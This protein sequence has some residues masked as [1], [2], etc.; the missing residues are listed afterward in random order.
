MKKLIL[1]CVAVL[2]MAAAP[3]PKGH[4]NDFANIIPD[5][6]EAVLEQSLRDYEAKTTIEMAVVTTPSLEGQTI[7]EYSIALATEWGIG[8]KGADNGVLV[9]IAPNDREYRV[10]V[11]R[12]LEGDLT[13]AD[14]DFMARE[15]L[16]PA[17]RADPPD[18]AGGIETL[19]QSI[20]EHLGPM[21]PDQRA[22][23]QRKRKAAEER[24]TELNQ[25]RAV[26]FFGTVF[27]VVFSVAVVAFLGILVLTI[28]KW[29]RAR[30]REAERRRNLR[31]ALSAVQSELQ[32]L[33]D[34]RSAIGLPNL[35]LWMQDD[36]ELH[37][38]AFGSALER[39]F[40]LVA[41]IESQSKRNLGYA[42]L[43]KGELDR[44]LTSV[45]ASL[46]MLQTIP[47]QVT[48]FRTQTEQVVA[49][50]VAEIDELTSRSATLI[51][52]GYRIND[53]VPALDLGRLA[54]ERESIV[55]LLAT[56]GEGLTDASEVVNDKAT[57]L[58][59]KVRSLR[60]ALE[61]SIETQSSSARR[62][63]ALQKRVQSFPAL[64]AEHRARLGRLRST[65]PRARW[66]SF[67]EGLPV[68]ERTMTGVEP[69]LH[70]ATHANSMEAQLF[71]DAAATLAT[72]ETALG[73]IDAS[74]KGATVLEATVATAE[75]E[76]PSR[77][78]SVER[79]I[80]AAQRLMSDSDVGSGAKSRLSEAKRFL[81]SIQVP[82]PLVDWIGVVNLL[83]QASAKAEQAAQLAR[84]DI[85]SA[86]REQRRRQDEEDR[87][88]RLSQAAAAATYTSSGFGQSS[89][90]GGDS[91]GGFGGGSFGGG[92]ASGGW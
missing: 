38:D 2:L 86:A 30:K 51:K 91:F 37:G 56:R 50:A 23:F 65:A 16:V 89:S 62:L 19:V 87:R 82:A 71:V 63:T 76:Y 55:S 75:R 10:E 83:G 29:F 77:R 72:M 74:L 41:E 1:G 9:L 58:L 6:R 11:G 14:S 80:S 81:D 79:A 32:R 57:R 28:F 70:V 61:S 43:K 45:D 35:P 3:A 67:E 7:E 69:R 84:N 8:K 85:E 40:A 90:G 42:E 15:S 26:E 68:L 24:Q 46:R 20:V 47:E 60:T 39:A 52:K 73:V 5:D 17:F 12:G 31:T 33:V 48:A 53:I 44:Q 36:K 25:A 92:G 22:D 54:Q 21:T 49:E 34:E 66:V 18:Y 27:M 64:L 59:T 78:K 88:Q 13:D 4:V